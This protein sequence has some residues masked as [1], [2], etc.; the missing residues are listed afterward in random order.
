MTSGCE[1]SNPIPVTA[2]EQAVKLA[3]QADVV[4]AV[5][6]ESQHAER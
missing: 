5:L 6:G 3:K 2:I 1:I 4:V